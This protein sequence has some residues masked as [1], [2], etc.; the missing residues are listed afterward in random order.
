MKL[1]TA[2]AIAY[3]SSLIWIQQIHCDELS[4]TSGINKW[5]CKC[6]YTYQGN[7]SYAVKSN[8]STSCDCIPD[9]GGNGSTWTCTCTAKG[10]PKLASEN[11]DTN[12]FTA[13][14][15]TYGSLS[16][17]RVS[18]KHIS[19]KV[20]VII[21]LLC[22]ILTTFAFL[23]SA[24]CYIYRRDKRPIQAPMVSSDKETSCN[25]A[26]NLLS[27]RT[28]SALESETTIDFSIS[29]FTGC[30]QNPSSLFRNRRWNIHGTI[31]Q[32]SYSQLESA[33][34][35]FSNSNLIGVGGSSYVYHGQLRNGRTVAI[36]RLKTWGEP[37]AESLFLTEIELLSRLHHCHVVPLLGYCS[38]SF[39]KTTERLLVFEYMPNGNLRECLDGNSGRDIDWATRVAIAIGA[40][41]GLE[42][43]HEAA[44]PRVLHSD[45]KSTNILLDDTWRAKITDLGMAK[46]LRADG[47]PS[48]SN[49]QEKMLGT[50]GYFAPEY[51]IIGKA[52]LKSDVFS[53][54]VVLLELISGRKPIYKS[55]NKGEESLVIWAT[56][57]LQ[58]RRRVIMELADPCLNG[59][60]PE[61]EMQIMAYLA[62]ECLL[63]DP[64]DRP[65]MSEVVQILSTM[66]PQKSRRRN[67]P[68]YFYQRSSPQGIRS[69]S[70]IQ[71]PNNQVEKKPVPSSKRSSQCSLQ[72]SAGPI[73]VEEA[74]LAP[75]TKESTSCYLPVD[76]DGI[77]R[78]ENSSKEADSISANYIQSL[79]LLSAS[80]RS[81]RASDDEMV[82]L[83]EPRFESFCM[84]N[85]KTT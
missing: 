9:S 31:I 64:D 5:I 35:N 73:D 45:V 48:S 80:V 47:L 18:K 37:D 58:D 61:E 65:T 17:A 81:C 54:G 66:A 68:L 51:A 59:N 33:T 22:V 30:F 2:V 10:F 69:G 27:L 42:Y 26:T 13:C 43:L 60:F 82:D 85:I 12:C 19:S 78:S 71:R 7:H 8:C 77:L 52:S 55:T 67:I 34:K 50:F 3:L 75:L 4:D 41:R 63:L 1:H 36:K 28:S 25:S 74:R 76:V 46:C 40:A 11:L 15:C 62:K 39:G 23:A 72:L 49:S 6:S 44:A 83:T 16:M 38:E 84:S 70:H 53:F 56:P 79:I 24:L 32:F 57:R 29:T 21:L 14:Q 20:V